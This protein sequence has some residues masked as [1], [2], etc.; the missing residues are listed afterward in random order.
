M[1]IAVLIRKTDDPICIGDVE[2]LRVISQRIKGDAERIIQARV[3]KQFSPQPAIFSAK[4]FDLIGM[5]LSDKD[6]AVRSGEQKTRITNPLA[7]CS[8]W[9]P[10]GAR[11][12]AVA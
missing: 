10:G 7:I 4:D 1:Q 12:S 2:K 5:A 3:G 6:V 11:N 8:T 9:N